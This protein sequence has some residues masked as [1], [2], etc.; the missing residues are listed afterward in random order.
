M[1]NDEQELW[2]ISELL[3]YIKMF[4]ECINY[5]LQDM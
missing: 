1:Q 2:N 5:I 3:S 4:F